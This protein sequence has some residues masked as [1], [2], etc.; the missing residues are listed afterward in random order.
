MHTEFKMVK[1]YI[2]TIF[3]KKFY[4]FPFK[5]FDCI[6]TLDSF[7][8]IKHAFKKALGDLYQ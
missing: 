7:S 8:I 3:S 4:I 2:F 6:F 5:I 1:F